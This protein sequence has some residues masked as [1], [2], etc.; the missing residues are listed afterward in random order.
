MNN[1]TANADLGLSNLRWAFALIDGL[2]AAGVR[3]AVISPGSR[4]TPLVLACDQ[5]PAITTT[6]L[7]D[8]RSAGFFA[9]GQARASATPSALIATSGS[10]PTH[11][12]PAVVASGKIPLL[13][14][15][16]D[17]PTELH[18]WGANQTLDQ[19]RLFAS[20]ARAFHQA[21]M[22]QDSAAARRQIRLLGIKAVEQS[23]GITPGPVHI[24]LPFREPLVPRAPRAQWP[25]EAGPPFRLAMPPRAPDMAQIQH[26]AKHLAKPSGLI[27]CGAG[28]FAAGFAPAL[29]AL[30]RKLDAPVLADP[31][32][33]LRF[34]PWD[35]SRL[36]SR[37]DAFLRQPPTT[38]RDARWVLRFGAAPVSKHL[39][40]YLE[41]TPD[42]L[43]ALVAPH[44]D[45]PDPLHQTDVLIRADAVTFCHALH[46]ASANN[47][48]PAWTDH[49]QRLERTAQPAAEAR[50]WPLEARIIQQI[51][52]LLPQHGVLF[53]GNSQAIRQLD[54]WSGSGE[55]NLRILANR[56]VSGIDGNVSTVLG[57][58]SVSAGPVV[59]LLGDLS[60]WHDLG[61]F[62]AAAGQHAIF[63]LLN[64]GGGGIFGQLPQARLE[65]FEHYW[66]TPQSV[67]AEQLARLFGLRFHRPTGSD[68]FAAALRQALADNAAVH[69]IEITV[70]REHSLRKHQAYWDEVRERVAAMPT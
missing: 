2:A 57:L 32:S 44:A 42:A 35:K 46:Q 54:T 20:H 62:L 51:L 15:S 39:L 8:E 13:L 66:L 58:A 1:D 59:A 14:L 24:N 11:W 63:V 55:K 60:L 25:A 23:C 69:L 22:A 50:Q 33:G 12:Y 61:G 37:Y 19:Q 31:L 47:A 68:G 36:C 65:T 40:A 34:G 30:A 70:A 38:L 64:N 21:G 17:R 52:H 3:R 16:A 29:F 6:T 43:H 45:W 49:W 67:D 53:S 7:L 27:V 56:G 26:L 48:A 4:S 9:L 5:H 10:A 41:T 28:E 18:D